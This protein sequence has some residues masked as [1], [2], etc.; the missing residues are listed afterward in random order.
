LIRLLDT[1]A[2]VGLK[3]GHETVARLLRGSWTHVS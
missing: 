1:N 2:C 3:R